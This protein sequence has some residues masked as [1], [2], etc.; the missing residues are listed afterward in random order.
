MGTKAT[1]NVA[2]FAAN[3][4][5]GHPSEDSTLLDWPATSEPP[6]RPKTRAS[7]Q[8]FRCFDMGSEANR[9]DRDFAMLLAFTDLDVGSSQRV[10]ADRTC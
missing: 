9:A 3:G 4:M 5:S 10:V 1:A 7:V 6:S 2:D 8:A